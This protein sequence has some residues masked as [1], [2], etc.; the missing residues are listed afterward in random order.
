[1][2][3]RRRLSRKLAAYLVLGPGLLQ[4]WDSGA[5]SAPWG[6]SLQL[7]AAALLPSAAE[8]LTRR[9]DVWAVSAAVSA[10]LWLLARLVAPR[11][12]PALVNLVLVQAVVLYLLFRTLWRLAA[13]EVRT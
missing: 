9:G 8:L 4:I 11:P 3:S 2:R 5:W 10:V 6:V 7:F 12:L 1:M 13:R